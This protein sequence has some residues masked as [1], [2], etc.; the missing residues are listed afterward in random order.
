MGQSL[1]I[2]VA[3]CGIGGL[4][5][6]S[7]LRDQGHSVTIF[8]KY[9]TPRA[10]GPGLII[11]PPGQQVLKRIGIFAE[12][13]A[14][15]AK[16]TAIEGKAAD[17]VT[18][19]LSVDYAHLDD[20]SFGLALHRSA[21]FDLLMKAALARNVD[22]QA[23]SLVLDTI[24]VDG[25]YLRIEGRRQ[26]GPFDLVLDASGTGSGLSPLDA[27][28]SPHGALWTVVDLPEGADLGGIFRTRF[29]DAQEGAGVLPIGMVPGDAKPKAAIF[30]NMTEAEFRRFR[31]DDI[32]DWKARAV[33]LWPDLEYFLHGISTHE[34]LTYSGYAHGA[35][36]RMH[37][38]N[39]AYIG[40]SA[41][42]ASPPLGQGG[43]HALLDAAVLADAL[44]TKAR[45][46][47]A[48]RSYSR[49]RFLHVRG[50]QAISRLLTPL[51]QSR[52][53]FPAVVRDRV[54]APLMRI[55]RLAP[56]SARILSCQILMP[57]GR[58]RD[59]D[60]SEPEAM[61]LHGPGE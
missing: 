4:A 16:V 18:D 29:R 51:Y 42:Q 55:P 52:W 23:K 12:A 37:G 17:G 20:G 15:G 10:T 2:A 3:G 14:N 59:G 19:V 48:L 49:R 13:V 22:V 40:D 21:L 38:A 44:E 43:T 57:F 25:V 6:A 53:R 1:N 7:L 47:A 28:P 60:K 46:P 50:Y 34:E 11:Q 9:D 36:Y 45:I 27:R 54:V 39:I 33:A 61:P 56:I 26:A 8:D 58:W 24:N 32:E 35:L 5:A 31:E 30:W 41:H